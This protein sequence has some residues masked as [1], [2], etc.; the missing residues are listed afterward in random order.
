V[1]KSKL[2]ANP[3]YVLVVVV[4]VAFTITACAYGTMAYRA[5]ASTEAP[6]SGLM[7]FLDRHGVQV[8]AV[9][10]VILGAATMGA[11][12][13]DQFRWRES[14]ADSGRKDAPE[15]GPDSGRRIS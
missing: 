9:E 1:P 12:W 15:T 8:L 11:I 14:Q 3:F 4:G 13:L 7:V 5:I 6:T 2:P 10:L